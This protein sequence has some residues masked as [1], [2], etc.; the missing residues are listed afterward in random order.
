MLPN[1]PTEMGND[2]ILQRFLCSLGNHLI[3]L[4]VCQLLLVLGNFTHRLQLSRA[5]HGL[6]AALAVC[7]GAMGGTE[8]HGHLRPCSGAHQAKQ[9]RFCPSKPQS[10]LPLVALSPDVAGMRASGVASPGGDEKRVMHRSAM[11]NFPPRCCSH[12]NIF[13]ADGIHVSLPFHWSSVMQWDVVGKC[14][15]LLLPEPSLPLW[16]G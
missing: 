5:R 3:L 12:N 1:H 6:L 15:H 7:C 13:P 2:T 8:A 9:A 10:I 16:A 11:L 4:V 14:V